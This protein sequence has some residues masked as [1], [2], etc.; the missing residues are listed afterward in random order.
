MSKKDKYKIIN[1]YLKT[2]IFSLLTALFGIIAFVVINIEKISLIQMITSFM[3]IFAIL[4]ALGI[5]LKF[6]I[7]VLKEIE[8]D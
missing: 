5:S 8:K 2:F 4:V 3:G 6:L 7:R 1:D